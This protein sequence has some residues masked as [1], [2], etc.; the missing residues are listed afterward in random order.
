MQVNRCGYLIGT[1]LPKNNGEKPSDKDLINVGYM[2][3]RF[4]V[5]LDGD[6]SKNYKPVVCEN[7]T[8]VN[9]NSCTKSL[10]EEELNKAG[11][12]FTAIA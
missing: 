6:L 1:N 3:G 7:G 10:F 11:I 5:S 4:G 9:I 12:K 2:A 8:Y